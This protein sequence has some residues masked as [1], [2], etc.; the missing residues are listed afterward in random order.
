[1]VAVSMVAGVDRA[2]RQLPESARVDYNEQV[3][4]SRGHATKLIEYFEILNSGDHARWELAFDETWHPEGIVA[5]RSVAALRAQHRRR[6][7]AGR[8]Q[9]I[10][11]IRDIDSYRVEFT[12]E[13]E[14]KRDGPFVATFRD[15]RIYRLL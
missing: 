4:P 10:H 15:G 5:G 7:E 13:L 1:M 2:A 12:T 9:N 11:V 14:G 8:I 3:R 6:L